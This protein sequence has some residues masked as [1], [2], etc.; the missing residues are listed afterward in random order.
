M[1]SPN[2]LLIGFCERVDFI[3]ICA[4]RKLTFVQHLARLLN[5]MS[6]AS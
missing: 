2:K 4:Q 3:H 1:K 5:A 6:Y